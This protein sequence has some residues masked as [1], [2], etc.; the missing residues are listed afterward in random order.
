VLKITDTATSQF[1]DL[2]GLPLTFVL[3]IG[4]YTRH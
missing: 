3:A 1:F 2:W 4:I